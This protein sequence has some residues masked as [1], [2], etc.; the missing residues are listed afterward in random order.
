VEPQSLVD[1]QEREKQG[2]HRRRDVPAAYAA[3]HSP[4]SERG[5]RQG[6]LPNKAKRATIA[7]GVERLDAEV[8]AVV[9][10]LRGGSREDEHGNG[11]ESGRTEAICLHWPA[12][13]SGGPH[14]HPRRVPQ[15]PSVVELT[16]AARPW[17]LAGAQADSAPQRPSGRAPPP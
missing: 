11:R 17:D 13:P 2:E 7:A 16:I 9:E 8:Q 14:D 5:G 15:S 12:V 4:S 3:Q 6:N 10:E 1:S